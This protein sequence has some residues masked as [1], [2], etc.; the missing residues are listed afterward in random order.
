LGEELWRLAGVPRPA[1]PSD[2]IFIA[3]ILVIIM[4]L[5]P[6]SQRLGGLFN[7]CDAAA[8]WAG[9]AST[10]RAAV[11]RSVAQ[12]L[13]AVGGAAVVGAYLPPMLASRGLGLVAA[14][15]PGIGALGAAASEFLLTYAVSL[16]YLTT[17]TWGG[18]LFAYATP[19]VAVGAALRLGGA[20]TGPALNPAAAVAFTWFHWD[21][22]PLTAAQHFGIFW[23]APVVAAVMAKWTHMGRLASSVKP[24]TD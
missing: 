17:E 6:L 21:K 5:G 8:A 10:A 14:P 18:G 24:K 2:Y 11:Q 15:G 4:V 13:G 19:L 9:G 20:L 22:Q 3:G 7:P 16:V 23:A 1:L 12:V